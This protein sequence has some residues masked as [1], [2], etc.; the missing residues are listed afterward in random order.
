MF[1]F[2]GIKITSFIKNALFFNIKSF[3][4]ENNFI[5][6]KTDPLMEEFP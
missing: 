1:L 2:Q 6:K 3:Q 5:L 4:L